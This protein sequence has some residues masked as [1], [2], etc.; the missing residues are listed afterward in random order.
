MST[1]RNMNRRR[2]LQASAM[3]AVGTAI[4]ACGGATTPEKSTQK[5]TAATNSSG[6][7]STNA[8]SGSTASM[9]KP[10]SKIPVAP[11]PVATSQAAD[12]APGVT[13]EQ[14]TK[15][16]YKVPPATYSGSYHESPQLTSMVNSGKLPPVDKRLPSNPYVV[17][18][19]WLRQGKYGGQMN[20]VC[21]DRTDWNTA[22]LI[23]ESM[24][25][26]SPLRWLDDGLTVGAGLAESWEASSDLSKW[27]LHFRKG[28]KWS[29]G[30]PWTTEDILFWWEDMVLNKDYNE[31]PPD[32]AYSG[33]GTLMQVRAPDANTLVVE[34]DAP[35]PLTAY[36]FAR[37]VN[38]GIGPAWMHPKHYLK[39]F[40]PKYNS[41]IKAKDWPQTLGAKADY[42]TNP[43][44]PTMTGW[45]LKQYKQGQSS[46][47]E[48][49]PYYWCIDRWGNQLPY[50]DGITQT[51][52]QDPQAMRLQ[53]QQGK[54]D[55]IQGNYV[56]LS[57]GDV[58][59]FTSSRSKNHLQV[60]L[61]DGG[62][63]T[64][65]IFFFNY[66]YYKPKLRELIRKPQFRQA[67]SLAFNRRNV[68]KSVYF[69]TGEITTGT[70]S[71]KA[72]DFLVNSRGR[73]IYKQWRDSYIQYNPGKARKM[74]DELGL[75]DVNGDGWRE[76][77]DGSPLRITLDYPAPGTPEH[78][79][80]DEL[81]AKD[82]QA[83]GI[84]ASPNPL[85]GAGTDT[86][87]QAGRI[88]STTAW[89]NSGGIHEIMVESQVLVPQ[90]GFPEWWAPLES[91]WDAIEGTSE[92]KRVESIDPYKRTP[93]SMAPEKGGPIERMRK[94]Y[95][96]AKAETDILKRINLVW[97][98]IK[99]HVTDG[100]FFMGC[101]AN[102]PN[103]IL[104]HE[105][106][107]NVPKR[108]DLTLHGFSN[109]W[110]HPTPA[111]YDPETWYYENPEAHK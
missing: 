91:N 37:W 56:G 89:E 14:A 80:K 26:H 109:P 21:S 22:H 98:I 49:N 57:L 28:L 43:D 7:S 25:G 100:P 46:T 93:P 35:A 32:E 3:A 38:C 67:L 81:L 39:Q 64:G 88:M 11:S 111:V 95:N 6:V 42:S 48:R 72:V 45:K 71:P 68:Q 69:N 58:S 53:I 94:L 106:L 61:W 79:Q 101:V 30:Q 51:N 2:F 36:E 92:A 10:T 105:E 24:Y 23:Q 84:N 1:P 97:N 103:V 66:D 16:D 87:W 8:S 52:I 107:R 17:P 86:Q 29:D 27:T 77:P 108:E 90:K 96:Q 9:S 33:K 75:K 15:V 60:Y 18:H 50:L 19:K 65:S 59:S 40:H 31:S 104:V 63:G 62:S 55:Y 73:G 110:S 78:I 20:W 47:W 12:V 41:R 82:W 99:I 4:T 54:A 5:Q 34:Y 83:I 85:T 102:T 13:L 74:L 70:Y 76:M 44:C